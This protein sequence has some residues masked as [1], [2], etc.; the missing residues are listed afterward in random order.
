MIILIFKYTLLSLSLSLSPPSLSL[1]S[2]RLSLSR[3]LSP[4]SLSLSPSPPPS[5]L[6]LLLSLSPTSPSLLS[7]SSPP[8]P[9]SLSLFSLSLSLSLSLV[10]ERHLAFIIPWPWLVLLSSLLHCSITLSSWSVWWCQATVMTFWLSVCPWW[11]R[12]KCTSVAKQVSGSVPSGY[13]EGLWA[14]ADQQTFT[15]NKIPPTFAS[16]TTILNSSSGH[17][18]TIA[19]APSHYLR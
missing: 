5:H 11:M 6:P 18:I 8:R 16:C 1:L 2:L 4:L 12:W 7:L 19:K 13:V 17:S 9:S 3:P 10:A 15:I 14:R